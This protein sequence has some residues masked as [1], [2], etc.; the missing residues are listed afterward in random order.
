MAFLSDPKSG[1]VYWKVLLLG[2]GDYFLWRFFIK[3][4]LSG[5][6]GVLLTKKRSMQTRRLGEGR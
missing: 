6:G 2:A 5:G 3:R 1:M 4:E